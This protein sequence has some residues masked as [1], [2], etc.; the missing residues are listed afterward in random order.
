VRSPGA[1]TSSAAPDGKGRYNH[2]RGPNG[3]DRSIYWTPETGAQP[4]IGA[5]RQRW[6]AMRW[7]RSHL[8]YPV[9][10]ERSWSTPGD[11]GGSRQ[12]RF[13]GGRIFWR[14]VDGVTFV[15]PVELVGSVPGGSGFGGE[16]RVKLHGDGRVEWF[17]EV[18]NSAYQDYDY[19]IYAV[20]QAPAD[21]PRPPIALALSKTGEI[22]MQVVGTNT[23]R[24]H[25][26]TVNPAVGPHYAQLAR[27]TLQVHSQFRGGITSKLDDILTTIGAW[28]FTAAVGPLG[29]GLIYGGLELGALVS[30]GNFPSGPRIVAGTLW[31]HGPGGMLF[32]FV[33]DGL[34]KIGQRRRDLTAAELR[35]LDIV[36]AGT[37]DPRVITLTDTAGKEGRAFAFPGAG[38]APDF[39][40]NMAAHYRNAGEVDFVR[41]NVDRDGVAKGAADR[42][43]AAKK[44]VHEAVHAWQYRYMSNATSYVLHGM[45][46]ST[47]EPRGL[48]TPWSKQNIEQQ[49]TL[50]E[51]WV[52]RH[53]R[54]ERQG[55]D[56]DMGLSSAAALGDP[57]FAY[58]I[59]PLRAGRV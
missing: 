14:D 34:T 52:Q 42:N 36:F 31:M 15:D 39:E 27:A 11:N 32:G 41:D 12:Q 44:L 28:T 13:Q 46:D 16:A 6:A 29:L 49:A 58:A 57:A 3:D 21:G 45:F 51:R 33:A 38:P 18:T 23:N 48:T 40:L 19:R 9:A 47:Y 25:E 20:V 30:G 26:E 1:T 35:L 24:W 7:E 22:N 50:V 37:I 17:G 54:P 4:V 55:S 5:I 53:F 43:V 8:G 59:A 2:V 10:A 56:P